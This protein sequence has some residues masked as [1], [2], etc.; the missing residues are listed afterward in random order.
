MR[1]PI[2][3]MPALGSPIDLVRPVGKRGRRSRYRGGVSIPLAMTLLGLVLLAAVIQRV[4]GLGLGMLFAPYAVVLIGA[5][6]GIM[7][8]N[9]LG[10][11]MPLLLLP[12]I[13]DRIQWRTVAW[14]G[15]P[16]VAVMPGAAWLSSVSP[17][18]PLYIVTASL[19][20]LSLLISV[21]L[22]R[23]HTIVDGRTAQVV[24]G[25][26]SG[27]GTVLGGVGGPAVTVYAVLSRWPV[28][29][30]VATLQPLWILIS[31]VSFASKLA[32]D[33]GQ[34]PDLPWWMWIAM[35]AIVIASIFLGEAVQKRLA[36]KTIQRFVMVLGFV[37]ALLALGTGV[38]L[39]VG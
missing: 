8:A 21:A 4:A 31:S 7:L 5:H 12:R 17:P 14:I 19:V 2:H 10:T 18:G 29:P 27:L 38:R 13:W 28:L 23:V 30:M 22:V 26:G 32:W 16:A 6:Q 15:L 33:D 36:E 34:V 11:L 20:L 35:V 1:L 37:G 3:P 25:I 39:L 24:T 9:F